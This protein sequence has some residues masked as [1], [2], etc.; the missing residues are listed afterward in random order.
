MLRDFLKDAAADRDALDGRRFQGAVVLWVHGSS[1]PSIHKR[2]S[3]LT[4]VQEEPYKMM[5]FGRS[6]NNLEVL[7]G[8]FLPFEKQLFIIIADADMNLQILQYDPDSK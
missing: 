2:S 1:T 7:A 6:K 3:Q 4:P 5:I 8:E